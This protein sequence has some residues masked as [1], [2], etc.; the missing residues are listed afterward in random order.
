MLKPWVCYLTPASFQHNCVLWGCFHLHLW[1]ANPNP[2]S[3]AINTF[4]LRFLLKRAVACTS[5]SQWGKRRLNAWTVWF[6]WRLWFQERQMWLSDG[7][8]GIR[9]MK[10]QH[11][12]RR[13]LRTHGLCRVKIFLD[14]QIPLKIQRHR[15]KVVKYLPLASFK[16]P[17]NLWPFKQGLRRGINSHS[18]KAPSWL[19]PCLLHPL[20]A[21]AVQSIHT[22]RAA[23]WAPSFG[24][25]FL[26]QGG[27]E[28]RLQLQRCYFTALLREFCCPEDGMGLLL[29]PG[30]KTYRPWLAARSGCREGKKAGNNF[31]EGGRSSLHPYPGRRGAVERAASAYDSPFWPLSLPWSNTDC[32][33]VRSLKKL[34][35]QTFLNL[36]I[37]WVFLFNERN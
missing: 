6:L 4:S 30:G 33:D 15:D 23:A 7:E 14:T 3:S 18:L 22:Q 12:K 8:K 31:L 35:K 5:E 9:E 1:L 16:I 19:K 10:R 27:L 32:M 17:S 37:P 24:L 34:W 20:V 29:K 36:S 21:P 2:K 11:K 25:P 26:Q 28:I 13:L